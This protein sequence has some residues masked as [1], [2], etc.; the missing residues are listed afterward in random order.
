MWDSKK[1][2]LSTPPI[3]TKSGWL[4]FYHGISDNGTY[5]VGALLLDLSDPTIVLSRSALPLFEPVEPYEIKGV[6]ER[7]VFPCGVILKKGLLY[8]YYGG[9]DSVVGVATAKLSDV[10]KTLK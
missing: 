6:V 3:K 2:G 9:A 5:R 8:I 10:L 7:V 4:L 1:V